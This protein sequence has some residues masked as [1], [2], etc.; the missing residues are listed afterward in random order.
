MQNI[1]SIDLFDSL[2]SSVLFG[3]FSSV[4]ENSKPLPV[5]KKCTG[6]S[7]ELSGCGE[8]NAEPEES[9]GVKERDFTEEEIQ[10]VMDDC[11]TVRGTESGKGRERWTGESGKGRERWKGDEWVME[12]AEDGDLGDYNDITS[13]PESENED[14][15]EEERGMKGR[16]HQRQGESTG[17]RVEGGDRARSVGA[18]DDSFVA[19][20][21]RRTRKTRQP[22]LTSQPSPKE[23]DVCVISSGGESELEGGERTERGRKM[24]TKPRPGGVVKVMD[25]FSDEDDDFVATR[26]KRGGGGGGGR[27]ERGGGGGRERGSNV[28]W[29][30]WL[31][32]HSRHKSVVSRRKPLGQPVGEEAGDY[33]EEE[34]ELSGEGSEGKGDGCSEEEEGENCYDME[35][36]FI[37]DNSVLTQVRVHAVCPTC[38]VQIRCK[39]YG[40]CTC[41][42]HSF[43]RGHKRTCTLRQIHVFTQLKLMGLY[44]ETN[45]FT[46]EGKHVSLY[47]LS[48]LYMY[49]YIHTMFV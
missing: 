36:S 32:R 43:A 38:T 14:E 3:D 26:K 13:V 33:I 37:N 4:S 31:G 1:D 11:V 20:H 9:W 25:E 15:V 23:M 48:V 39:V 18:T 21:G 8:G 46:R 49:M 16:D 28:G 22:F 30:R 40:S 34:A 27:E 24:K 29:G 7:H 5:D 41:N 19:V 45:T 47:L 6:G 2:S 10:L 12:R 44:K 42:L 35:D 17:G